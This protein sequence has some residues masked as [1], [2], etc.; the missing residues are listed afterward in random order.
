LELDVNAVTAVV[1]L[2]LIIGSVF[3]TTGVIASM[4]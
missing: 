3:A 1:G 2:A 4:V